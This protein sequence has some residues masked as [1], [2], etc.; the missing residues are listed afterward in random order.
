V[1]KI[2]Q[3]I[4]TSVKRRRKFSPVNK[5]ILTL[6]CSLTLLVFARFPA[7]EIASLISN[8]AESMKDPADKNTFLGLTTNLQ[9]AVIPYTKSKLAGVPGSERALQHFLSLLRKWITVE[10]WFCDG[11]SYADAVDSL[12]RTHKADALAVLNVCRSHE[13]V[14]ASTEIVIRILSII[15]DGTRID[16]TQAPSAIGKRVSI[17]AG[18]ESL[19]SAM[20]VISE[21]GSMGLSDNYIEVALRARKLLM[22]ESMPSLEQR[23]QK[24]LN[25]AKSLASSSAG[26]YVEDE[27][28]DND[29][30]L[31]N[32]ISREAEAF[33]ADHIPMSDVF[34]PLLQSIR[35]TDD[36][37]GLIELYL[38]HLYRPYTL[39]QCCRDTKERLV[40]FTFLNK[41]SE[42][43]I[44]A[45]TSVNSMTDLTRIVSSG[46]LGNLSEMSES[47]P[48]GGGSTS[49]VTNH[50][51]STSGFV[52]TAENR[53]PQ[54]VLRSGAC[55]IIEKLEDM[56]DPKKLETILQC[57][58]PYM[59]DSPKYEAGPTNVL[60]LAIL[61]TL[62]G[63]DEES[64]ES[65]VK[66][67]EETLQQYQK[68]FNN[69]DIRRISFV[70]NQENVQEHDFQDFVPALFTFRS[71]EFKEDSLYRRIDPSLAVHLHLNRIAENFHI[72]SLGSRHTSIC[73]V[74]LYGAT[75]RASALAKDKKANRSPRVFVRALSFS[76]E[77]SSA[78]Y[79][80]ILVDALNA[81]DLCALKSKTDNHLF[82]NLVSD[83]ERTVLDPVVV[84]QVVVAILKHHGERVSSLGIVEVETRIVCCL[85]L[86]SPPIAIRLFASNPTG[87]VHVMNTYIEA[88]MEDTGERVFKLI[89]GTKASLASAGDS[90]WDGKK[91]N[92]PY[93][94]TRPFDAQRKSALSATDTIY[95]YDIPALF[96]AAVEQQWL[97][98]AS[99]KSSNINGGT[100]S[101]GRPLM[102]MY[103]TELVVQ[104]IGG[105]YTR[106]KWTMKDY[107]NHDLELA[108]ST[109]GAGGNDVGMVAW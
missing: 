18:A 34:F 21:I 87:Y 37:V 65:T 5:R 16:T 49:H 61:D 83:F 72:K 92:T 100:T 99:K 73:Q 91:V 94:L 40:K 84:E 104:K 55:A 59:N 66:Q 39:K 108:H 33:L 103:T 95:C 36:E 75:P 67:C 1:K 102:V 80:R 69:A 78:G 7:V 30:F 96:E 60:Y 25:A 71:P 43:V 19:P 54:S 56:N 89:S 24:V 63:Q 106:D 15:G 23:R 20:S 14:D 85:S 88:T 62:T 28:D 109:R 9:N 52:V 35:S 31:S 97:E 46:S 101:S 105:D 29:C 11:K 6:A 44:N 68:Q 107:L 53:I 74:H 32:N 50:D 38:R 86:D 22:Q 81:L 4:E 10:R 90:S 77:F 48:I 3:A 41:P 42:V 79:E 45:A 98:E 82:L 47:S 57:F 58:P 76:L 93:P 12:R 17:V 8:C 27:D 70:F 2:T 51:S 26:N 64:I 13:Q